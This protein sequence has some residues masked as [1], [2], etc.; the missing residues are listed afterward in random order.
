MFRG[1]KILFLLMACSAMA[2]IPPRPAA[3]FSTPPATGGC[4][5]YLTGLVNRWNF[6]TA[7]VFS[8]TVGSGGGTASGSP[9]ISGTFKVGNG[10][11]QF[12][13]TD[14]LSVN[15]PHSS[16]PIS[17]FT[18]S[19]WENLSGAGNNS[20]RAIVISGFGGNHACLIDMNNGGNVQG[21]IS[22]TVNNYT[23]FGTPPSTGVW[24]FWAL[25]YDG[26]IL[27]LWEDGT[28]VS[29][30]VGS[31]TIAQNGDPAYIASAGGGSTFN[32]ILD[33]LRVYSAALNGTELA[34]VQAAIGG[35][36]KRNW[37]TVV[38]YARNWETLKSVMNE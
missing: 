37:N 7:T 26:T 17:A 29:A 23:V 31:G 22:T 16:F 11:V 30:Q 6:D 15:L 2:Q 4:A 32:G 13:G 24:H 36:C 21:V 27:E 1:I 20:P 12:D 5:D 10:A 28:E 35:L 38:R 18:I 3:I 14:W 34:T 25:T 33:D 8:D 9:S 19:F